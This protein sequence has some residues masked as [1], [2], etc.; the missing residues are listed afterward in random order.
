MAAAFYRASARETKVRASKILRFDMFTERHSQRLDAILRSS[1]YSHFSE[2]LSGI[3]TIRAYR[4][5]GRFLKENRD[6]V[7][8]ENRAYWLTVTNQVCRFPSFTDLHTS[9]WLNL[10]AAIRLGLRLDFLGILLILSVSMLTVGT[11]FTVSPA[12]RLA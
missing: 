12:R 1:L 11:R 5:E 4:E 6:W 8:I 9:F 3:A 7:D 10:E 2:S